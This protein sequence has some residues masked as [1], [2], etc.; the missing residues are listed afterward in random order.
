M[1][2]GNWAPN[3]ICLGIILLITKNEI[4]FTSLVMESSHQ[5]DTWKLAINK[6]H[7]A[8]WV[9]SIMSFF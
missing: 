3:T 6:L 4:S 5:G 2:Y 7:G 8:N 1:A 9:L